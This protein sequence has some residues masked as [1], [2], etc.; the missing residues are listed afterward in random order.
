MWVQQKFWRDNHTYLIRDRGG[1]LIDNLEI[2]DVLR[3]CAANKMINSLIFLIGESNETKE[4]Y[5]QLIKEN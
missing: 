4:I 1:V 2:E 5:K 3:Y